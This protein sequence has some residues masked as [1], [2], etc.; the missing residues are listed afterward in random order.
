M[1]FLKVDPRFDRLYADR[2][3]DNLLRRMR[4]PL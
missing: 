2:R 1:I 4:L 3:F